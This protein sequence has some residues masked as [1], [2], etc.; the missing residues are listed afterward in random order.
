MDTCLLH[1]EMFVFLDESGFVSITQGN[2]IFTCLYT[3]LF[4]KIRGVLFFL[5]IVDLQGDLATVSEVIVPK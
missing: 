3:P 5:R 1:A 4:L 2:L